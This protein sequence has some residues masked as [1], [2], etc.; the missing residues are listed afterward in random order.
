MSTISKVPPRHPGEALKV[1]FIDNRGL[2]IKE[3]S[4]TSH[5]DLGKLTEIVNG[6]ALLD[7]ETA[8]SLKRSYG[9]VAD[10]LYR[11]QY[12]FEVFQKHNVRPSYEEIMREVPSL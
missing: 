2:P 12:V 6:K 3:V 5:I 4:E 9:E 10:L 1:F 7:R 11:M 8:Y